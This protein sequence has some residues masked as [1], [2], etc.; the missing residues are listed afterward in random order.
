MLDKGALAFN[1][2][3]LMRCVGK[4]K[5]TREYRNQQRIFAQGDA[6]DALFYVEGGHVKLWALSKAGKKAVIAILRPGH[7]FGEGCMA[8][9]AFRT[10]SASAIQRSTVVRVT[11]AT[12]SRVIHQEPAFTKVFIA[13]LLSRMV[14]IEEDFTDQVF[15][16]SEKRLAR[17]LLSLANYGHP[18][19]PNAPD[20]KVSQVTL[21]EM[22][23]TTRSRVSFFMNRF[24]EKG[25]IDYNGTLRVH[26]GLA[27]FLLNQ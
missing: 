5:T 14:Q 21:A 18:A 10:F 3:E 12:M 26:P 15:N 11:R 20:V 1:S 2:G 7:L 19:K 25:F 17:I 8:K 24:R 23:G 22:I 6:A 4:Q 13:Y 16:P 27:D 9:N